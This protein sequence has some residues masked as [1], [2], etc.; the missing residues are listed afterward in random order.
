MSFCNHAFATVL[1]NNIMYELTEMI[2]GWPLTR[3]SPSHHDKNNLTLGGGLGMRTQYMDGPT[4]DN[5]QVTME[6]APD[7]A[8]VGVSEYVLGD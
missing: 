7:L 5:F 8:A 6:L 4:E 1:V 3:S 2:S